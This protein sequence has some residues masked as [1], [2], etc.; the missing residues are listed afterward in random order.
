MNDKY[1]VT[2]TN[3]LKEHRADMS[4]PCKPVDTMDGLVVHNAWDGREFDEI[5]AEINGH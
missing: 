3:D 4:C 5:E 2:P 1:H